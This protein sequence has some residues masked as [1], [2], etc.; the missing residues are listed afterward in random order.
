[1]IAITSVL[2]SDLKLSHEHGRVVATLVA[3]AAILCCC[4]ST[5]VAVFLFISNVPVVVAHL[6]C[7]GLSRCVFLP[8]DDIIVRLDRCLIAL[9]LTLIGGPIDRGSCGSLYGS[10]DSNMNLQPKCL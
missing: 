4:V 10:G 7:I 6:R 8:R 5:A 3:R 2:V 1:M 9:L